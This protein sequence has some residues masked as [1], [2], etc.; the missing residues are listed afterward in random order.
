MPNWMKSV[1]STPHRPDVAANAT[2]IPPQT[3]S[4]RSIGQPSSTLA[5]FAAARFTDAMITTLKN[6]PRYTAR[7]PRTQVAAAPE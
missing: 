6:T 1:T 2:L 7:K 4:V 3:S 5:I